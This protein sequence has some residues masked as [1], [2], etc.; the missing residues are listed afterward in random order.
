MT[1]NGAKV[2]RI[3]KGLY[4]F[5]LVYDQL[6]DEAWCSNLTPA[7]TVSG[8]GIAS[9]YKVK[10]FYGNNEVFE[11]DYNPFVI[12]ECDNSA[13]IFTYEVIIPEDWPEFGVASV[14]ID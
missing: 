13:D 1:L 10:C 4:S 8:G 12:A 14:S 2:G 11:L 6:D 7:G 5:A 3:T 9:T